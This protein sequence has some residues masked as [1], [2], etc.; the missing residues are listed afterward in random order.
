MAVRQFCADSHRQIPVRAYEARQVYQVTDLRACVLSLYFDRYL[1]TGGA[2]GSTVR[3]SQ[4]WNLHGCRL[5]CLGRLA[6]GLPHDPS[7]LLG[8]IEAQIQADPQP[9]FD[10]YSELIGKTFHPDSFYSTPEGIVLY[11]QQYDIA[12]YASGIREF[13]I[14]YGGPIT[15]PEALCGL[16]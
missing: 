6:E 1:Y 11:Y 8:Q 14:P 15:N 7:Y 3:T 12:P 2:H 4:T 10:N 13:L 16:A 5:L 9:Y